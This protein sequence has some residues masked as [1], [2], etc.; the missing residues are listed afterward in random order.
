MFIRILSYSESI[1]NEIKKG[2]IKSMKNYEK[3]DVF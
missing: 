3:N 1:L 2:Y